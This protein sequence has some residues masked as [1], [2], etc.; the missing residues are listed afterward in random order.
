MAVNGCLLLDSRP[1][2]LDRAG[3]RI[4]PW[5]RGAYHLGGSQFWLYAENPESWDS[6]YWGPVPISAVLA[7][8][9]PML[10]FGPSSAKL[11]GASKAAGCPGGKPILAREEGANGNG[12]GAAQMARGH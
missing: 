5:P 1:V 6:R 4:S 8:A 9:E 2:A 12:T 3:R 7:T 10:L 11:S